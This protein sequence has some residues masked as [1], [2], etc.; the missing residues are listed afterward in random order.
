MD[1]TNDLIHGLTPY[2]PQLYPQIRKGAVGNMQR[3]RTGFHHVQPGSSTFVQ[4]EVNK[5]VVVR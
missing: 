2:R 5:T 4:L 1:G 3:Q